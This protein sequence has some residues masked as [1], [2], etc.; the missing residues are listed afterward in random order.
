MSFYQNLNQKQRPAFIIISAILLFVIIIFIATYIMRI[1]KTE[2][3]IQYAPLDSKITLNG[4]T[5]KNKTTK[6][7]EPGNYEVIVECEHFETAKRIVTIDSNH[8][9]IVGVLDAADNE[10]EEYI[11]AHKQEFIDTEGLIGRALSEE[12]A[13]IK[14]QYPILNYLPINN[15]L[16][17]ISYTYNKDRVPII[18]VKTEPEYLDAAISKMKQFENV[19]LT[20]YQI[21]FTSNNPFSS[22]QESIKAN[23][24]D[25]IKSTFDL[26]KYK[27]SNEQYINE[28]YFVATLY[29]YDYN[30]DLSYG[31]YRVLLQKQ[32]N[33]WHIVATPQPLLTIYNTP[34]T[35]KEI[36]QSANSPEP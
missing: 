9:Y 4:T 1:G 21:N 12:G 26:N 2:V 13:L 7:L 29:T 34:E 28:E 16:Y 24:K 27:I 3:I 17:S 36:L 35:N 14:E 25:T 22:Y 30:R 31:H 10:G 20:S 6:W 5:I 11:E 33:N 18:N 23:P 19:D 32:D 8:K 15:N